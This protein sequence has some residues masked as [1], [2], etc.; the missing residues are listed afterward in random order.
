[1]IGESNK[2]IKMKIFPK[3][4]VVIPVELRRKYNLEIGDYIEIETSDEGILMK[5]SPKWS[6]NITL[7]KQLGGIFKKYAETRLAITEKDIQKATES[8]FIKG[9]LK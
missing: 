3:G 5:P 9:W 7:T 2:E 6:K 4:Q 8:N 1:M